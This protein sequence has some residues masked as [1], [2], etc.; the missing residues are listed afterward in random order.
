MIW[1]LTGKNGTV[2]AT[3]LSVLGSLFGAFI[4]GFCSLAGTVYAADQQLKAS[5]KTSLAIQRCDKFYLP[6]YLEVSRLYQETQAK[7]V[8]S[9]YPEISLCAE[10]EKIRFAAKGLMIPNSVVVSLEELRAKTLQVR[11]CEETAKPKAWSDYTQQCK[12]AHLALEKVVL[13]INQKYDL[14]I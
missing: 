1:V 9:V 2:M 13:H 12:T 6:L 5:T 10:W 14:Q 3:V 11:N 4:G 7:S 8:D